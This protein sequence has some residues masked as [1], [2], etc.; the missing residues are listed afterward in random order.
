MTWTGRSSPRARPP[1]TED[2]LRRALTAFEGEIAQVPPAYS[3][4]KQDGVPAYRRARRGEQ[5]EMQSRIVHIS[6]IHLLAWNAPDLEFEVTCEAGTYIRSIAHDLGQQLGCGASLI[7]LTRTRSGP[8]RVEDALS[9]DAIA[10]AAADNTIGTHLHP[11]QDALYDLIPVRVDAAEMARLAQGQAIAACDAS[12][13][14]ADAP[15]GRMGY[16]LDPDEQVRAILR[17]DATD[18][19]WRPAKVFASPARE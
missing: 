13:Q 1:F 5:V 17:Y 3:A 15:A 7:A 6:D 2:D 19:L 16:A 10:A 11:L 9:P 14:P 8:F 18:Q 12:S 4:I